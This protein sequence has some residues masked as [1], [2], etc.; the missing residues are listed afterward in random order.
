MD[1]SADRHWQDERWQRVALLDVNPWFKR[2]VVFVRQLL[3]VP[4]D[5]F[6]TVD[7][8]MIWK[9]KQRSKRDERLRGVPWI[10]YSEKRESLE[11]DPLTDHTHYLIWRYRL[12][13]N[14]FLKAALHCCILVNDYGL[15]YHVTRPGAH[16]AVEVSVEKELT[17]IIEGL[18]AYITRKEWAGLYDDVVSRIKGWRE[19]L[20]EH[21]DHHRY[22]LSPQFEFHKYL[23]QRIR[24]EG[25]R[26]PDA[27]LGWAVESGE[28]EA[29]T[30]QAFSMAAHRLEELMR[31]RD[32]AGE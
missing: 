11:R 14:L 2:D 16:I 29:I 23:Y 6:P 4:R 15:F 5:G 3:G 27:L 10:G 1:D 8:A 19:F 18:N 12:P 7:E 13:Q 28:D 30:D 21:L 22:K 20:E 24:N 25:S 32:D 26:L 31:P 9:E 17:V